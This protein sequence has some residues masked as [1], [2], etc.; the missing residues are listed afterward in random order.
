[1]MIKIKITTIIITIIPM[2]LSRG[3]V[4]VKVYIQSWVF[5]PPVP[6][7]VIEYVPT[8]VVEAVEIVSVEVKVGVP[9]DGVN[10]AVAP[11]GRPDA[12]KLTVSL[13]PFT[14]VSETVAVT[15]SP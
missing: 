5:P 2:I 13:K 14:E 15:D 9:D 1:M 7:M 10:V 3:A 8:G 6:V 12:D 4:T 11:D